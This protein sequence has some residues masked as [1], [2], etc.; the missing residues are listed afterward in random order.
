MAERV[1]LSKVTHVAS[2]MRARTKQ[3]LHPRLRQQ[4]TPKYQ[5]LA[6]LVGLVGAAQPVGVVVGEEDAEGERSRVHSVDRFQTITIP[7]PFHQ[8][9]LEKS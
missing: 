5:R 6:D 4:R 1:D 7:V 2:L 8:R 3:K 9:H